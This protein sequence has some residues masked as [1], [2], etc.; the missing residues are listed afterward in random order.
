M[1]SHQRRKRRRKRERIARAIDR[2]AK[3]LYEDMP[4]K[5]TEWGE[6][7]D[8]LVRDAAIRAACNDAVRQEGTN[9]ETT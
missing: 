8:A 1:N 5:L 7:M 4:N 2:Y 9:G 6:R 3:T